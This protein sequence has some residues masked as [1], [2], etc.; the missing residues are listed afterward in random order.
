MTT[1]FPTPAET[2][3]LAQLYLHELN[4][5][6]TVTE[7]EIEEMA[8]SLAMGGLLQNLI[9][10]RQ[11]RA[12]KTGIV[13]GGRRLRA[14]QLLAD[15]GTPLGGIEDWQGAIPVLVTSDPAQALAW[16][17]AENEARAAL[18]PAD[19]VRLYRDLAEQS[20]SPGAIARAHAVSERRVK[21]RL[22]LA[23]LPE[24][25]L[26]ALAAG[27]IGPDVAAAMT[28]STDEA[29]ILSVLEDARGRDV[30]ARAVRVTLTK[31]AV[32]GD[33]RLA[34]FVGVEAYTAA[35]GA[36]TEDLFEDEHVFEDPALLDR[37]FFAKLGGAAQDIR[38]DEGWA[39]VTAHPDDYLPYG[40]EGKLVQLHPDPVDLPEGD[41]TELEALS[42]AGY[43]NL[44]DAQR[45]RRAELEERT[46]G[47]LTPEQR[48]T[49]TIW[50]YVD[51]QGTL[52][53]S[54]AFAPAQPAKKPAST[55]TADS[56]S[57]APEEPPAPALSEALKQDLRAIRTLALQ[58][59]L[60]QP[61]NLTLVLALLAH[62]TDGVAGWNR[63]LGLRFETP[64]TRVSVD[65]GLTL[66]E[67]LTEIDVDGTGPASA[68][69]IT[70]MLED[71]TSAHLETL[72]AVLARAA[73][74]RPD[75]YGRK[76]EALAETDIRALWRPTLANFWG[77]CRAPYLD[78][79]WGE[80]GLAD[81]DDLAETW[82]KAKTKE[83][84]E[85][86]AR[87]FDPASGAREAAGLGPKVRAT[88]DTWLPEE[89]K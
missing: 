17:A 77:R 22:R 37:L 21:Q 34:R 9:G 88:I 59:A 68:E 70:A 42:E 46:R 84:A 85:I 6:K 14:L 66:P 76:I 24:P 81:Y 83:K 8:D 5:R 65:E 64:H 35:G 71:D 53:R 72:Q 60:M 48:A 45:A 23:R 29:A 67:A 43:W 41:A 49:A 30:T 31:H 28:V 15:R 51:R 75:D 25:V 54:D 13:G 61:D 32:R 57:G 40:F 47:T 4:P 58:H 36:I 73:S 2:L 12:K 26:D 87:L 74:A 62:E 79:V 3:P 39:N 38:D 82:S 80:L 27:E 50:I 55:T 11:G 7:A 63:L 10:L 16:A 18:T 86:L 33:D 89:M 20:L 56:I 44:D 69:A 52:R 19:E 78:A 1:Q